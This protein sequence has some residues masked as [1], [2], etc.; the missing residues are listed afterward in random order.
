MAGKDL[1][2][3]EEYRKLS[4]TQ[5]AAIFLM[6]VGEQNATRLLSMMEDEEIKE[7]SSTMAGLGRIKSETVERLFLEFTE[8]MSASGAIIGTY[9]TTERLLLKAL[10]KDRVDSIM[11]DI[12]G[13][14][15]R[16]TWDKLGNV[17]EEI[18]ASFLKNE[19]PQTIALVLSK[20]KPDHAA[21]V[22]TELPEEL[23][24]EV[25]MRML[26]MEAVKKEVMEGI[27]KTLRVEFMSNLAKTQ[28]RDS[29]EMM[30]E[31][32]NNFDRATE[33]KFMGRLEDFNSESAERIR[34]LMFTFEDLAKID[35]QGIQSLLR[36]IDKEKLATALKGA[37][38]TIKDLFFGS[39]SERAS[40][41][42]KEDI[43][44]MGPVRLKDVDESQMYIVGVAK[45]L[46][47][48]GEIIIA[49]S[50]GDDQLVY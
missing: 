21:R 31:V 35:T 34:A 14:A 49:D 40:K 32:F 30:A 27:E 33:S 23:A 17:S 42:L 37:S 3:S 6:S 28:R 9:D 24:M 16:T 46:A 39:M 7:I 25:I 45:D 26:S 43:E 8:Q 4:G 20:I 2:T 12:R 1:T 13:P 19:Y 47:A 48:K 22:L 38:D 5:K 36:T 15:G 10:G 44:G 50:S 41:I 29:H 11:E 18:L